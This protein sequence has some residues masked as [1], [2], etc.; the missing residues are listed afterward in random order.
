V[1]ADGVVKIHRKNCVNV[2]NE[3]LQKS[4]RV[5]SVSWNRKVDAEFLAGIRIVGEDRLGI[6]NQITLVI[7]KFDTNI[8]SIS[9][10]ARDGMFVGTVMVYV[11]N[12]EKLTFLMDKL[13]KVAGIF[14][15]ERL[16]S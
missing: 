7:S 14:T 6:S 13:K 5:V 12:T 4:E 9:L 11:R 2:S 15:V 16:I 8:R 1:T 10:H 3:N